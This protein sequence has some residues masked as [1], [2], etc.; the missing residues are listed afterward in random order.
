MNTRLMR[1]LKLKLTHRQQQVRPRPFF[2]STEF[3]FI[4][5]VSPLTPSL[6]EAHDELQLKR[7]TG[8]GAKFTRDMQL[9]DK[10][11]HDRKQVT[12]DV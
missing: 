11:V 7:S 5:F 1:R 8:G 4:I 10:A 6:Q 9:V 12:C 2:L 3:Q